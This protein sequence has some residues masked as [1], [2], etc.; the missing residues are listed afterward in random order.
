MLMRIN[1]HRTVTL[2][3]SCLARWSRPRSRSFTSIANR[4]T[5]SGRKHKKAA[6]TD[7]ATALHKDNNKRAKDDEVLSKRRV[8]L[9]RDGRQLTYSESVIYIEEEFMAL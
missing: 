9:T 4:P 1:E 6:A 5:D 8:F 3:H 7:V 2:Y